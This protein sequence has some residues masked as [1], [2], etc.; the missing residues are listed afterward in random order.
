MIGRSAWIWIGLLSSSCA[1][2]PVP[3]ETAIL[4][5]PLAG[6]GIVALIFVRTDCPIA[7]RYAPTM[8]ELAAEH[9]ARGVRVVLVYPDA[10][11]TPEAI[12]RHQREYQLPLPALR[13]PEHD[14]VARTGV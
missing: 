9:A 8:R 2:A 5:D 1:S 7:N 14:W 13:D 6:A 4:D 10:D 12:A 11:A 3:D